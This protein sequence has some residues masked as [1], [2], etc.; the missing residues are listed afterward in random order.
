MIHYSSRQGRI[1]EGP[2]KTTWQKFYSFFG[3]YAYTIHSDRT[4]ARKVIYWCCLPFKFYRKFD[5]FSYDVSK[6]EST[7]A[8]SIALNKKIE[9]RK[10]RDPQ[11]VNIFG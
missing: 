10:A 3:F 2:M 1:R 6:T 8:L 5:V 7:N 9:Q 4:T 11:F